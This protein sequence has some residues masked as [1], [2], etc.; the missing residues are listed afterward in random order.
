MAFI[1]S[2]GLKERNVYLKFSKAQREV[3]SGTLV[4]LRARS[5]DQLLF[6]T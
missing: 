1:R 2:W 6:A 4:G 3:D 5:D